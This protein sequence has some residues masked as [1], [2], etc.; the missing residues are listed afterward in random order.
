MDSSGN[1][2]GGQVFLALDT[3]HIIITHQ[4]VALPMPPTVIEHVSVLGQCE[5]AILTFTNQQGRDIGDSNPQDSDPG[6]VVDDDSVIIYPA[7]KIPGVDVTAN[8]AEIEGVD[9]DFIV[10]PTGVDIDIDV[11]P[12]EASNKKILVMAPLWHSGPVKETADPRAGMAARNNWVRKAA[13]KYV[14][15]MKGNKYAVVLTQITSLLHRSKDG[16]CMAQRSVS[17]LMGKG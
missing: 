14:P 15:S 10:E 8:P 7:V 6:G 12:V 16:L 1:L 9:P 5:P 3:H 13:E 11:V 17:K 2:S 4:W